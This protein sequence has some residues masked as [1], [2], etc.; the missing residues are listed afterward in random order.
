[1]KGIRKHP[2][3]SGFFGIAAWVLRKHNAKK[4]PTVTASDCKIRL[5]SVH[6]GTY[7]SAFGRIELLSKLVSLRF[8]FLH[9]SSNSPDQHKRLLMANYGVVLRSQFPTQPSLFVAL[10]RPYK[11]PRAGYLKVR[12]C[13]N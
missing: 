5:Y 3:F 9:S 8:R 13:K 11:D 1:M 10:N 4:S 7:A 6:T 2:D 12:E